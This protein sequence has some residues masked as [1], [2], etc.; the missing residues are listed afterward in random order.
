M[1]NKVIQIL[2]LAF[3]FLVFAYFNYPKSSK[4]HKIL[5]V[6]DGGS[7]YIDFNDNNKKDE[8]E[9]YR[10]KNVYVFS[11]I[12]NDFTRKSAKNL[13]M[14]LEQYLKNGFIARNWAVDNLENKLVTVKDDKIF[15]EHSDLPEFYLKNGLAYT[16]NPD[17]LP[18][19]NIYQ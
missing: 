1:K 8:N 13:N 6:V 7:F 18:K 9:F 2:V 14:P 12:S 16:N 11:D 15:F 19:Q 17:Y 3:I 4:P 10:M 5:E